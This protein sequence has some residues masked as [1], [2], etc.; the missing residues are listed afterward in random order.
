ML[1]H[2]R[3]WIKIK[4]VTD[5][6]FDSE[7]MTFEYVA[8]TLSLIDILLLIICTIFSIRPVW[9]A[10]LFFIQNGLG[11]SG[12]FIYRRTSINVMPYTM[13]AM[14]L[15]MGTNLVLSGPVSPVYVA[16]LE[17]ITATIFWVHHKGFR[18]FILTVSLT[19][20]ALLYI[21]GLIPYSVSS[22]IIIE[23]LL[24]AYLII[25]SFSYLFLMAIIGLANKAREEIYKS[26][27]LLKELANHDS[28]TGLP[29]LRLAN[30]RLNV[31]INSADRDK[32]MVGVLFLDLD[33]FKEINDT[34]GHDAGDAVLK[35]VSERLSHYIR[36]GDTAAR[37]GGDE[38]LIILPCITSPMEAEQICHRLIESIANP[39][40]WNENKIKISISI[41]GAFYPEHGKTGEEIKKV[42]DKLMY[43]VKKQGKNGFAIAFES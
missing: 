10:L 9:T 8:F 23:T 26:L 36:P 25:F 17:L 31:A 15:V 18:Y 34:L 24:I 30:D 3:P 2:F 38:F 4:S 1:D 37:I 39:I 13:T 5:E 27:E 43:T 11:I 35:T 12:V 32:T 6:N 14:I 21:T 16:L 19:M 40:N 22:I 7:R 41:G 29:T 20:P 28:L 42:A 33:K